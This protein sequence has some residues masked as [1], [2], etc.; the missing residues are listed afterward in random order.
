ML[1]LQRLVSAISICAF[2]ALVSVKGQDSPASG[3][4]EDIWKII[5]MSD[6]DFGPVT[7]SLDELLDSNIK[8]IGGKPAIARIHALHAEGDMQTNESDEFVANSSVEEYEKGP[9]KF[10]TVSDSPTA[11]RRVIAFDGRT[12]WE[13]STAKG[14]ERLSKVE[15]RFSNSE[16]SLLGMLH[17]RE[18]LP[19]MVLVGTAKI[20]ER[21]VYVVDADPVDLDKNSNLRFRLLFDGDTKLLSAFCLNGSLG[22]LVDVIATAYSDYRMVNGVKLPFRVIDESS[23]GTRVVLVRTGIEAN[24]PLT[25]AIFSAEFESRSK[26][27]SR[28]VG[29]P[30]VQ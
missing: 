13:V 3:P 9:N 28:P 8:A 15:S 6:E 1:L 7:I 10:K 27:G 18:S 20:R 11:G 22:G 30:G 2:I 5:S 19:K 21:L 24:V 16:L 29:D 14:L 12:T 23:A 25:N 17:I 4:E 26:I